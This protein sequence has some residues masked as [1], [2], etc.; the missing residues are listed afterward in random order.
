M[1]QVYTQEVLGIFPYGKESPFSHAFTRAAYHSV[2]KMNEMGFPETESAQKLCW[3]I[4]T[5]LPNYALIQ[6]GLA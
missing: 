2:R 6:A 3:Y 4:A 5:M 1:P